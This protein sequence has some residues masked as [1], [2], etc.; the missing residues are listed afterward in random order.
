MLL[1]A[2]LG[3]AAAS[4]VGGGSS[5]NPIQDP[6]RLPEPLNLSMTWIT[7]N[8]YP[9]MAVHLGLE[10]AVGVDLT[11]DREGGVTHCKLTT[12]SGHDTLDKT[13]CA[14]L[15]DRASFRPATD[16]KGRAIEGHYSKRVRWTL[17]EGDAWPFADTGRSDSFVLAE[18]GTISDCSNVVHGPQPEGS[19]SPC[20]ANWRMPGEMV[21]ALHEGLPSGPVRVTIKTGLAVSDAAQASNLATPEGWELVGSVAS[22][23]EIGVD[24]AAHNCKVYE[25]RGSDALLI[26]LCRQALERRFEAGRDQEGKPKPESMKSSVAYFRQK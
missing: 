7:H 17:P 5:R 18:D 14:L 21:A 13:T 20:E 16:G 19:I 22:R 4:N 15:Q 24:G 25:S 8:D 2:I 26:S 1:S 12:S 11:I 3:L 10:G 6:N 23:F 9:P